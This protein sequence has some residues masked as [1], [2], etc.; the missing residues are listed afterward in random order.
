MENG[1]GVPRIY[2]PQLGHLISGGWTR[3]EFETFMRRVREAD[4]A[5]QRAVAAE[6]EEAAA[7]EWKRVFGECWPTDEEVEE[8][9]ESEA[10]AI[11]PGVSQIAPTGLVLPE[12]APLIISSPR[13]RYDGGLASHRR[14]PR[15]RSR[16]QPTEQ[17]GSVVQTFRQFSYRATRNG[18]LVWNGTLAP[19]LESQ[20]YAIRIVHER[21][22]VPRVFVDGRR[23]DKR[24]RHIYRDGSLCLYW[25]EEWRWKRGER[26]A[27]T[28]LPWTAFWLYYYELWEATGRWLGP[29]SPHGLRPEERN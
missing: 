3:A 2:D 14:L 10:A 7:E 19:T 25:T 16:E 29:S 8:G 22:D 15:F 9:A 1:D 18:G 17:I 21:D 5:A 13:T 23:L 27:E 24:C 4:R 12:G 6:T 26:I 20:P 28:L 11:G